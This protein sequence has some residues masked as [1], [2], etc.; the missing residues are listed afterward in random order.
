M[1]K[2][3]AFHFV[4]FCMAAV[5]LAKPAFAEMK[6]SMTLVD[7]GDGFEIE[8]V[9]TSDVVIELVETDAG[10]GLQIVSGHNVAWPGVT[11]KP[12]GDRWDVSGY[13][14]VKVDVSNDG[15][16]MMNVGFR[17]DNPGADGYRNCL[18]VVE[19]LHP[20][21]TRTITANLSVTSSVVYPP[22]EIVGM[23]GKPGQ[24]AI[25][26]A[27]IVK[28]IVF[29]PQPTT[30]HKFTIENIRAEGDTERVSADEF[31]PFIDEFG[32]YIHRDWPGK[33]HAE[34]D[35]AARKEAERNDM[36]ANPGPADRNQY[37]G[38]T[39]GPQLEAT[40]FFRPEKH[41]GKWWLVDPEG[42]LFWSHGIDCVTLSNQTG[43][44]G[45][46][47]YF[48]GLPDEQSPL[49]QFYGT[50]SWAPHGYY[51]DKTPFKTFSH[52]NA[53][54]YRKYGDEWQEVYVDLAHKRLR[55]WGI[56]TIANWSAPQIC[57][58]RRT[59]YVATVHI[60]G[61]RLEGSEGYWRK[62]HDVF[63]PSFRTELRRNLNAKKE[64][65][66]DPWC[67]GFFVD[68]ELDWGDETA[69]A[70]ATLI[71]PPDHAAKKTFIEDL[72]AKY[73]AI[74]KLNSVWGTEHTSW[75]AMLQSCEAPDKEKARDDLTE[76]YTKTAE[77]YFK[78]I[79]DE[80]AT[81]APGQL[82]LGCRFAWVNDRAARAAV[83]FCD[84]VSYNKYTYG[85]ENLT[86]PD[87]ADRPVIIGE[88]HFGALDRGMLHTGLCQATDQNHR[89]ELYTSYVRSALR[90]PLI[91]GT[92]WFQYCDQ[93]TTGRGD[94]ENYQI[95]FLDIC[96]SPYP[97]T[98][99]SS[100]E[101]GSDL[102]EYRMQK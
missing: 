71:S 92:H 23:R 21:Q 60:D 65:I 9:D 16:S 78:T 96:D 76:F 25:D 14:Q 30:D 19:P 20:G 99:R 8:R 88:F 75:A 11:F 61:K 59:P 32:Q 13:R 69:L 53:N 45:R 50:G 31:F 3:M 56:N 86:L 5:I 2:F 18:Q 101:V 22:V 73:V 33:I 55:S 49:A 72:Q 97:E 98:V 58:Q 29:V 67:I 40:G 6:K 10:Q 28:M 46:E 37:G 47:S 74:E 68:N 54:L 90:N 89:A 70:E 52:Q 64:E 80:L 44:T 24:T 4:V 93:P 38:W 63:D 102:Y 35:F 82:Y 1:T 79:K 62:F 39:A 85:V 36:A 66:G 7:F 100:R 91:V 83:K 12:D 57:L 26:P 27:N 77:T 42:R 17:I 15:E 84:V 41:D 34:K 48:R 95:G 43:T 87:G 51:K 81:S 94:G